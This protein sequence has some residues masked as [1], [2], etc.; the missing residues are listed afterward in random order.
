MV[1]V[2]AVLAAH[3]AALMGADALAAIEDV[4]RRGKVTP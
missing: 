3:G 4:I 2:R 1:G